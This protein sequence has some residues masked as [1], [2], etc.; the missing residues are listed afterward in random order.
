MGIETTA[1]TFGIGI[2]TEKGRILANVIDSFRTQ[3]GG[4]IPNELKYHHEKAK[5]KVL[6]NALEKAKIELKDISL[7]SFS[8][9]PGIAPAL[10]VGIKFAKKLGVETSFLS[11]GAIVKNPSLCEIVFDASSAQA[12]RLHAPILKSLGKFTIDM[13]PSNIGKMCIPILNMDECLKTKN[14]NMIS[15]GGQDTTPI[16]KAIMEVHP[17]TQYIEIVS[18]I[19]SKS[20]GMG[21][22]DNIDE[23]TQ[24]TC[25][26]IKKFTEV[27]KAKAII[28][29]NPA[30]PPIFM[31]NTVLAQIKKPN[32]VLLKSKIQ[33]MVKRIKEYVPGY[34]LTLGPV[35]EN[36]RVTVM[37]EVVG[38]G[39]YLPSYAGNLDIINCAAIA[40]GEEYAKRKLKKI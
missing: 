1:H 18:H 33:T 12:H 7:V 8:Q 19:A 21:T 15:C 14:I 26:G 3:K 16:A 34:K 27:A 31:H 9:G 10:L 36:N 20:A 11:I 32:M 13:T 28:I 30:E 29:L 25:D 39:D 24:T 2:V 22:R 23:Y 6:Q 40:V 37:N 5:E 4:L 17:E 35:F 38:R